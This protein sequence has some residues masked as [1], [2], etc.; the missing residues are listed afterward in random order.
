MGLTKKE[1]IDWAIGRGWE[2]DK[3]GH[4]QRTTADGTRH[5]IKLSN[6]MARFEVRVIHSQPPNEWMRLRSGY[7]KDL[8]ISETGKLAGLK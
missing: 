1:V 2:L 5:R 8:R 4:L 7:Y 3:W 6:T